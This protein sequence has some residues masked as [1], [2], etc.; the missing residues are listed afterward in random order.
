M[1]GALGAFVFRSL[2]SYSKLCIKM[3]RWRASFQRKKTKKN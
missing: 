1:I 2:I 3:H